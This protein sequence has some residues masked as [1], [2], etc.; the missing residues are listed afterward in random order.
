MSTSSTLGEKIRTARRR[1]VWT[2]EVLA[3]RAMIKT[4]TLR[5]IETGKRVPRFATLQKIAQALDIAPEEMA[6]WSSSMMKIRDNDFI[7]VS[8]DWYASWQTS[9]HGQEIVANQQVSLKQTGR[10]IEAHNLQPSTEHPKGGYLWEAYLH[11]SQSTYL[12]GW[13]LALPRENNSSQG[14]LFF[15]YRSQQKIFYGQWVG[16]SY[17]GD[18]VTGYAVIGKTQDECRSVMDEMIS[19]NPHKMSISISSLA[20]NVLTV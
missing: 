18:I 20:G 8:G 15:H 10:E 3:E 16:A 19:N 1:R 6:T 4:L 7:D 13:Y 5:E 14:S 9:V 11:L 17:D 12:V 2:Q